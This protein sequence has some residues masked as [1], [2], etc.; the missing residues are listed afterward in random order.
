[1]N[2]VHRHGISASERSGSP[3]S[4]TNPTDL[5]VIDREPEPRAFPYHMD[6]AKDRYWAH[7]NHDN[8]SITFELHGRTQ[9]YLGLGF[10]SNGGMYGADMVIVWVDD[11]GK[12]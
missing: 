4:H 11:S 12:G 1:M 3:N 8:E 6:F 2:K 9:G 10:S 7:W 5:G